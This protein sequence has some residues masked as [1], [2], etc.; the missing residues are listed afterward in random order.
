MLPWHPRFSGLPYLHLPIAAPW[1]DLL[2]A[3]A[4]F[5]NQILVQ[6]VHAAGGG[7]HEGTPAHPIH[8]LSLKTC[9]VSGTVLGLGSRWGSWG[10]L[11]L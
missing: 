7:M 3:L 9:P 6:G 1:L 11:S 4:N 8:T 5:S 2:A 10:T